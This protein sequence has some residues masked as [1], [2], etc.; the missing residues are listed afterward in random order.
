MIGQTVSHYKILDKLGEGGM[1]VV[2]KAQD[3]RLDRLVALKFL[4]AHLGAEEEQK[5][6][7]FQEAKAASA[8]DHP[9]VCTVYE[10]DQTSSGQIF[11]CMAYYE[12]EPL[13]KKIEKGP[14]KLE[15]AVSIAL[16]IARGLAK[17]HRQGIV[18]R[19]I[20][21]GNVVI[22]AD[23][24]A[25]IVDFGL[26][27]LM[28][29]NATAK[30]KTVGTPNYI[31]PEQLRGETVDHRADLW[32]LGVVLYEMLTGQKPFKGE[33][34][35]AVM[36][37]VLNETP[38]AVSSLRKEIPFALDNVVAKCLQKNP[39]AR[40]QKAEDLIEDLK[41]SETAL[42][43]KQPAARSAAKSI[44]V[45]PFD[46]ISP[47]AENEYFSDGL[48]E[49][50]ITHLS[51]IR[52]LLVISRTSIMRYKGVKKPLREIAAELGVQYVLEGS[53]RKQGND[54][55]ITAQLIDASRDAHLWAE[56]YGGKLEDVFAIQEKVAGQIV[57]ALKLTLSPQEQKILEKRQTE[58]TEAYELYL[59]G[60][61]W[62][63]KRTEEGMKRG[64][65]FF[66]QA[67]EKD[68]GYALAY[69]GLADAHILL[70][71][72]GHHPFRE[73][74][75]KAEKAALKA[76]EL[77]SAS[78]EAHASLAHFKMLYEWDWAGGE[79]M[80]QRAIELNPN[81]APAHLWYSLTLSA[82]GKLDEAFIEIE[83]ARELDPLSLIINTDV[84]MVHYE[85]RRYDQAFEECRK[86]M[87]I[88][89][90]F[91]VVNLLLGRTHLQAG[92]FEEAVAE[93]RKALALSH[94]STLVLA[95]LG[96]AYARAG[97]KSEALEV[98]KRL[99]EISR[100]RYVA[101]NTRAI[102][103]VG[104]GETELAFE[105]LQKAF[106]ERSL[107]A[108]H[109]PLAIDPILDPL[110]SDPRFSALLRKA[111]LEK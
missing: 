86:T 56:K 15:E 75:P 66:N 45:L 18:H 31:S 9:N 64:I 21:S 88:D 67:I 37:A 7:F 30:T 14:L 106:E 80:F 10:I 85:A 54:L 40:Y 96:Y 61:F 28:G 58:N 50:I 42:A 101:P 83:R 12:G 105:W 74:M 41:R 95:T 22:T 94:E 29:K 13:N 109:T 90:N 32:S 27:K 78:A 34:E 89:P 53:V 4:P 84:G 93:L 46:N 71:V 107:W 77:D 70:G 68:P 81:Y 52:S 62:W 82:M 1:G 79:Q 98:L 36:Y 6:R 87:E 33:Y 55:R 108:A 25:K 43:D 69:V 20:K 65:A 5:K 23:G 100:E 57:D 104:L 102:L 73:V 51:K 91:Y 38:A 3:L 26:A 47:D 99:E 97:K 35:Q 2:Y 49:E 17:A 92:N 110:R 44:A 59:K 39:L 60:R 48:T 72:Y 103:Y 111:G 19:D 11:I 76:L 8:L 16:Q 63:N 24:I